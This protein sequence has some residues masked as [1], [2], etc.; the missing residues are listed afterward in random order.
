MTKRTVPKIQE[1]KLPSIT[2]A[3]CRRRLRSLISPRVVPLRSSISRFMF[4]SFSRSSSTLSDMSSRVSPL[5][6]IS[7]ISAVNLPYIFQ[8]IEIT[9]ETV[10][11]QNELSRLFFLSFVGITRYYYLLLNLVTI[12]LVQSTNYILID[13]AKLLIVI[14]LN[15][16][17]KSKIHVVRTRLR[18]KTVRSLLCNFEKVFFLFLFIDPQT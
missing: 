14:K 16:S 2:S 4:A 15:T 13:S 12:R 9:I 3:F 1:R 7:P 18:I 8:L 10:T 5:L 17:N 6:D 11:A